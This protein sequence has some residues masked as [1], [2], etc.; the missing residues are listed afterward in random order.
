M[1]FLGHH[2][3]HIISMHFQHLQVPCYVTLTITQCLIFSDHI[4]FHSN[5]IRICPAKDSNP[6]FTHFWCFYEQLVLL[7]VTV[8]LKLQHPL[9]AYP[10]HLTSC[11]AWEG[12]NLIITH[13]GWGIWSLASMSCYKINHGGDGGDVKLSRIQRKRLHICGGLVENQRPTQAVFCSRRCL[14]PIYIYSM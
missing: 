2:R 14:R 11:L 5:W 10:G 12:G 3:Q 6:A 7:Y 8:K 13:R 1:A 9:Q 4:S